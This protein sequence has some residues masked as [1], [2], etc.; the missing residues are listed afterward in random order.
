VARAQGGVAALGAG[1]T[2]AAAGVHGRSV[3]AR[4]ADGS[5]GA[6][7]C[8]HR[9]CS[10]RGRSG[11]GGRARCGARACCAGWGRAAGGVRVGGPHGRGTLLR[12][13]E[14]CNPARLRT[15]IPGVVQP[16]ATLSTGSTPRLLLPA[17]RGGCEPVV[18]RAVAWHKNPGVVQPGA[19]LGTGSTPRLLLPAQRG[20]CEPVVP[21]AVAWHKN[22]VPTTFPFSLRSRSN[23][24]LLSFRI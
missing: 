18:P 12:P 3:R 1:N 22:P 2:A 11:R 16:G 6:A 7:F 24:V 13:C 17:Q 15:Q 4:G 8:V 23:H 21:R 19:M 9:W 10:V 5:R 20:G 14:L